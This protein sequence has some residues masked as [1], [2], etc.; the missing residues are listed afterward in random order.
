MHRVAVAG[1]INRVPLRPRSICSHVVATLSSIQK[2]YHWS[3]FRAKVGPSR[4]AISTPVMKGL[5]STD[6]G[7][8]GKSRESVGQCVLPSEQ[9]M[10]REALQR[11]QLTGTPRLVDEIERKFRYDFLNRIRHHTLDHQATAA[12][13]GSAYLGGEEKRG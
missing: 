9:S 10:I 8:W 7:Q 13:R 3:S 6:E 4:D 1:R 2:D 5:G 11:G 12:A